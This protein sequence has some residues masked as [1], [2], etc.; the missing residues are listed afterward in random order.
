MKK[1]I[2]CIV[3]ILFSSCPAFA[4]SDDWHIT[5]STHFIVHYKNA[6]DSFLDKLISKAEGYYLEIADNLGFR[7]Y[8][9]WLWENRAKIYI[10]DDAATYQAAT[11]QPPW[12]SGA[13]DVGGKI[14]HTF[15]E[16]KGFFEN[17]LP[18]EMGHI[19][20]RE[21]IGFDNKASPLW[22]DEGVASFQESARRIFAR[23]IVKDAIRN[24][25]F[26][27][28]EELSKLKFQ[29]L[30]DDETVKIFYSEAV[31]IVDYLVKEFGTDNF[32]LFCQR[33]RDKKSLGEALD[34]AYHFKNLGELGSGWERY[35]EK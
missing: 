29:S 10:Y 25:K 15:P 35:L 9:F 30:Q 14:I 7:R 19:I 32:V 26:I 22:L 13:A 17:L 8:N 20:Y 11:K 6:P 34:Y 4:K 16:A 21:F 33:L 2:F 24:A 1:Y 23:R 18:H 27:S 12:S 28:I 5:K 3:I 31:S